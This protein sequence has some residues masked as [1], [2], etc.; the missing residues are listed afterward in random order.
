[1]KIIEETE[2]LCPRCGGRG[3][4]VNSWNTSGLATCSQCQGARYLVT[5]RVVSYEE[6]SCPAS[7]TP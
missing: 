5:K 6:P 3:Q 7:E 1:M 4:E 2:E